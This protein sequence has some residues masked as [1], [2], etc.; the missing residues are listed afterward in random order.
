[1]FSV[2]QKNGGESV[3]LALKKNPYYNLNRI[4]FINMQRTL[5]LI[6]PDAIQRGLLEI[7]LLVLSR[8]DLS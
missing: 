3:F 7:S 6:K 5:V 4:F 2:G 8:R 1:M